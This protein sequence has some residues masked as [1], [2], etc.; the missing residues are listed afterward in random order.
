MKKFRKRLLISLGVLILLGAA[1]YQ[2]T[3]GLIDSFYKSFPKE[4]RAGSITYEPQLKI[5]TNRWDG[6]TDKLNNAMALRKLGRITTANKAI[7]QSIYTGVSSRVLMNGVGTLQPDAKAGQGNFT[8]LGR[9]YTQ[10]DGKNGN[11]FFTALQHHV[12]LGTRLTVTNQAR[13]VFTY[14]VISK[15][16]IHTATTG[17]PI[18]K[19]VTAFNAP[20]PILTLVTCEAPDEARLIWITA[21]LVDVS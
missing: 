10:L 8:L 4:Q 13:Q 3:P 2:F 20:T 15:N 21:K 1:G 19:T 7:N 11:R 9:N 14:E 18:P 12:T 5:P 17:S 6:V 16:I